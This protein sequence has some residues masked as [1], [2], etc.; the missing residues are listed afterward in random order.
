VHPLNHAALESAVGVLLYEPV[1]RMLIERAVAALAHDDP[2]PAARLVDTLAAPEGVGVSS[3]AYHAITCA[4]YRVSPSADPH[5]IEAVVQAGIAAGVMSLRTDEVYTSQYP[6]LFWPYQ[7]SDGTRPAPLTTTPYPVFVL[8]AT[9]DPITPVDQARAIAGRLSDGYLIVTTGGS[10]V[11]FGRS[12]ECVDRP[13]LDFLL[14]GRRPASRSITCGG[15]VAERYVPLTPSTESGYTDALD[16]MHATEA[17]LFADPEYLLRN[18]PGDVQVGCRHGGFIAIT[19]TTEQENIRFADCSF[20]DGLPLRGTG[21]YVYATGTTSWSVTA[22]DTELEYEATDDR[23][24][25]SGTWKGVAVD[26]TR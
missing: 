5:D 7:P 3:F 1:G 9:A 14:D 8:G 10:H 2:V 17:E 12:D 13:I 22:P 6:C 19:P 16:A 15:V 23:Q 24:H 26:I 20:V 18:G 21:T 4:D 25:V 11:S